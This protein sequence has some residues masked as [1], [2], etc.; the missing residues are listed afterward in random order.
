M[1]ILNNDKTKITFY[2]KDFIKILFQVCVIAGTAIAL[3]YN[4]Q[5]EFNLL[6]QEVIFLRKDVND[7]KVEF[8]N[9]VNTSNSELKR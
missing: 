1:Q 2:L 4:I 8:R 3:F 7:M 6:K 9:H 5:N